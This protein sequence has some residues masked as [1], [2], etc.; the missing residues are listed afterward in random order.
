MFRLFVTLLVFT[1]SLHAIGDKELLSRAHS[2]LKSKSKTNQ[3]RAY[4]DYKNLYLRALMS[5]D[6]TLRVSSLKGIVRSGVKLHIDVTQY[7]TEL[8]KKS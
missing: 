1:L 2:F 8:N 6:K 4:N 7:S 3:F 5:E